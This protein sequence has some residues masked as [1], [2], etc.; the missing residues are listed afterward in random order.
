MGFDYKQDFAPPTILVGLLCPWT[1]GIFFFGGVSF[2]GGIQHSPIDGCSAVNCNFG[3]LTG[4]DEWNTSINYANFYAGDLYTLPQLL[5][6]LIS[7]L[8]LF[9]PPSL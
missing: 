4:E 1:W 6:C 5:I 9:N 2:F 7:L 8:A 3:V